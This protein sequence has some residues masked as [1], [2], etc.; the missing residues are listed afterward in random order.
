MREIQERVD[1]SPDLSRAVSLFEDL[2]PEG[3]IDSFLL[4]PAEIMEYSGQGPLNTD[5]RDI[6]EFSAPRSLYRS[7]SIEIEEGIWEA[8]SGVFPPFISR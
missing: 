1:R 6:L 8:R 2:T 3:L 5:D 7:S 4:G